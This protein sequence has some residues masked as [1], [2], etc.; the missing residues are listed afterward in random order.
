MQ[1]RLAS[2]RTPTPCLEAPYPNTICPANWTQASGFSER[3]RERERERA[4]ERE[5]VCVRERAREIERER[6]RERDPVP[7]YDPHSDSGLEF[8][9]A[10][11][12][13]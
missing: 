6:E 13:V 1:L 12:R 8:K 4:R 2:R 10:G 9:S 7:M 5:S 3:E 11:L